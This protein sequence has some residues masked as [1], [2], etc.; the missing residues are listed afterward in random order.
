MLEL[1]TDGAERSLLEAIA[2]GVHGTVI[3]V[4]HGAATIQLQRPVGRFAS[5]RVR[6]PPLALD[7][8]SP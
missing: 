2:A 1:T 6:V 5:G 8:L 7:K 4:D 3:D